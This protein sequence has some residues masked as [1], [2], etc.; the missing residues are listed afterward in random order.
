[1]FR[2]TF[3]SRM[4]LPMLACLSLTLGATVHP[5]RADEC[6]D[7]AQTK[8]APTTSQERIIPDFYIEA[9]TA[10]SKTEFQHECFSMRSIVESSI[11]YYEV[12]K[13]AR[14]N[15]YEKLWYHDG[16]ALCM[17]RSADLDIPADKK[18]AIRIV[19]PSCSSS[20]EEGRASANVIMRMALDVLRNRDKIAVVE[21]PSSSYET[22]LEELQ[23]RRAQVLPA[24]A[25]PPAGASVSFQLESV[26]TGLRQTVYFL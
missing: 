11:K 20:L 5:L 2:S 4:F 18:I 19:H 3:K 23:A 24:G 13:E 22:I 16:R 25:E 8:G 1:M 10:M 21:V 17:E 9:E 15:D 6:T 26:S 7:V 12:G 14:K